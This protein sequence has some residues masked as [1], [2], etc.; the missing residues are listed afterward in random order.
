MSSFGHSTFRRLEVF[1]GVVDAGSFAAGALK[2]GISQ[3]AVS[4]HVRALEQQFGCALF[5]RRRGAAPAITEMGRRL[6]ERAQHLL[7]GAEELSRDLGGGTA[8]AGRKRIKIAPQRFIA[9]VLLC[10]PLADFARDFPGT[11]IV[12]E[13]GTYEE[14]VKQVQDGSADVAY[15]TSLGPVLDINS[16]LVG[17]E[18]LGFY[19]AASHPLAKKRTISPA[20][21]TQYAFVSANQDSRFGQML[22]NL[23]VPAGVTNYR[24][25]YQVR[26]GSLVR[27]LTMRGVGVTITFARTVADDVQSG[28]LVELPITATPLRLEVRQA[29]PPRRPS[30]R[31]TSDFIAYLKANKTFDWPLP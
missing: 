1:V 15:F 13:P 23:L 28:A 4:D 25:A 6:Y 16:E 21:L 9:N 7:E 14:V 29:L 11:D 3:P 18:R 26:E 31:A 24:V 19:A 17:Y 12:V 22:H 2:L 27:E 5:Q 8:L 30:N 10:R 20:E